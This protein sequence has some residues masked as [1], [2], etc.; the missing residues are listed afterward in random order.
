MDVD[1][2]PDPEEESYYI[3]SIAGH[4]P[5]LRMAIIK[6]H[7]SA[8]TSDKE[9][10]FQIDTGSQSDILPAWIYKQVTG[11][12]LLC[13][14]KPCIKEIVSYTRE[15]TEIAGKVNLPV[16]STGLRKSLNFTVIDGDY[17]P[18]L[19]L[20]TSIGL[21]LVSLHNCDVRALKVTS[22]SSTPPD[23]FPDVF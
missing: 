23:E 18:V 14:L 2:T 21:G 20:H 7:V 8:P 19:S 9:V 22:P 17:Q 5:Q 6:L 16:W 11:D 10:Q 3:G 13:N 4:K 15:H 12:T 1:E